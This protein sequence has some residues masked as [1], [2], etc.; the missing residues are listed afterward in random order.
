MEAFRSRD[1]ALACAMLLLVEG[2]GYS[3]TKSLS[4][5]T[6]PVHFKKARAVAIGPEFIYVLDGMTNELQCL[7]DRW[8]VVSHTGSYG[9]AESSFDNP[10]DLDATNG[11]DVFVADYG[12]HRIQR[13]DRNLNFVG[14]LDAATDQGGNRT[15]GY[16]RSVSVSVSG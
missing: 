10:P 1:I 2:M 6:S 7:N 13:F 14:S 16:P 4:F 11:L 9:W 12:N 5:D 8:E 15:F 3:H